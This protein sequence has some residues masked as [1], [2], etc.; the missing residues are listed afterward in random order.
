M[1][2]EIKKRNVKNIG[3]KIDCVYVFMASRLA[4]NFEEGD[5]LRNY[6]ME[7]VIEVLSMTEAGVNCSTL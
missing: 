5:I 1:L 4:R 3:E 6:I 7:N 2:M